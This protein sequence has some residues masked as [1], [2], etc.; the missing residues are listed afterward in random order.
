M[1]NT[2]L[3][4]LEQ[5]DSVLSSLCIAAFTKHLDFTNDLRFPH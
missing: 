5:I 3:Q 2:Y 1:P 4:L